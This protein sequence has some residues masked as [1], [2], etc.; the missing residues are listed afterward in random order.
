MQNQNSYL[1]LNIIKI[2]TCLANTIIKSL[3]TIIKKSNIISLNAGFTS[4]KKDNFNIP[5]NYDF[6][7]GIDLINKQEQYNIISD[8]LYEM[9]FNFKLEYIIKELEENITF[10][11]DKS[12]V[13]KIYIQNITYHFVDIIKSK[14]SGLKFTHIK[15]QSEVLTSIYLHDINNIINK[16]I[17][18]INF[19]N[20]EPIC[21][22]IYKL[23]N[24]YNNFGFCIC[25]NEPVFIVPCLPKFEI[26][27]DTSNLYNMSNLDNQSNLDN[28]D[29]LS[30][31]DNKSNRKIPLSLLIK[32]NG[33]VDLDSNIIMI[34]KNKNINLFVV[35]NIIKCSNLEINSSYLYDIL[36]NTIHVD[37]LKI[38]NLLYVCRLLTNK[39]IDKYFKV[40]LDT[41]NLELTNFIPREFDKNYSIQEILSQPNKFVINIL[42]NKFIENYEKK[43]SNELVI[44]GQ[45]A[46]SDSIED[47]K[48]NINRYKEEYKKNK[49]LD[50]VE[51]FLNQEKKDKK[52]LDTIEKI[53][54]VS[55]HFQIA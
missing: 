48:N 15:F 39:L 54:L 6:D 8:I 26:K 23:Y 3:P 21:D 9:L 14:C 4:N 35:D 55:N 37:N 46:K 49:N 31:I 5:W 7:L 32:S 34:N 43:I 20:R 36:E 33:C 52:F 16:P 28:L 24:D 12:I 40:I 41:N 45:Y 47:I 11:S 44:L 30:N 29:N 10:N 25:S 51:K 13:T 53:K 22:N 17:K 27:F 1:I 2:F 19:K 50:L 38:N 42:T 18:N